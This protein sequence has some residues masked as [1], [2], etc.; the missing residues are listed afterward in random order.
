MLALHLLALLVELVDLRAHSGKL[1]ERFQPALVQRLVQD[2]SGR[3][4]RHLRSDLGRRRDLLVDVLSLLRQLGSLPDQPL[5]LCALVRSAFR[6]VLQRRLAGVRV[7]NGYAGTLPRRARE[8]ESLTVARAGLGG[9]RTFPGARRVRGGCWRT[10]RPV[11]GR[12]LSSAASM[13]RPNAQ[14][15]SNQRR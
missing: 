7:L 15:A 10:D 12:R 6:S 5:R 8:L 14:A 3:L 11:I 4:G 2:G 13:W 1:V 9:G